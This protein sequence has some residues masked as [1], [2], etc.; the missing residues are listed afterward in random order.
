MINPLPSTTKESQLLQNQEMIL[1]VLDGLLT[2]AAIL[3]PDGTLTYANS[4]LLKLSGLNQQDVIGK[5]LWECSW[6]S[7]SQVVSDQIEHDCYQ[8]AEGKL[9]KREIEFALLDHKIW[10]EFNLHPLFD[11]QGTIKSLV[12]EA[13]DITR[14]R[15]AEEHSKRSQ[16]MDALG[17]LVGGI[18]HDYNN[19]LGVI[20]G[21]AELLEM[22]C[23]NV[24]GVD[25]YIKEILRA[26]ER[27]RILTRKMLAFSKSESSHPDA[28][29][30]NKTL[31][32][33]EDMLSKSLTVSISLKYDL[34]ENCWP[35]WVD[36]S[37][38][39]DAILN[40]CINSKHAM[41]DGGLLTISTQNISLEKI[42]A[43]LLGLSSN[44]YVKLSIFDTG[45]G[46]SSEIKDQVFQVNV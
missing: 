30:I 26:G 43:D 45:C 23:E 25:S 4:T 33:L 18:A 3:L 29:D 14:R 31:S 36:I 42:D 16:K 32:D 5:K 40:M 24:E 15:L 20:L 21:Y 7:Y 38:L 11:E 1:Q 41:P 34:N 39:D 19:M 22:K 35:I 28:C 13:R 44:D 9:V 10:V 46:I 17:K 2:M 37:E 12:A 8:A 27:G 6:F